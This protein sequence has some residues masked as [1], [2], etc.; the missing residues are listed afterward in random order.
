MGLAT[1]AA[2]LLAS[3]EGNGY[4]QMMVQFDS[5]TM[6]QLNANSE[7]KLSVWRYQADNKTIA[8]YYT[9]DSQG[10][11]YINSATNTVSWGWAGRIVNTA[12]PGGITRILRTLMKPLAPSGQPSL[13]K[14]R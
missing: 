6:G 4:Y 7:N 9:P 8:Q 5:Q 11:V 2:T 14:K 3:C 1:V 10:R 12:Y 13:K